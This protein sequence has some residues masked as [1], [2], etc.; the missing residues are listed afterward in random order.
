MEG[1]ILDVLVEDMQQ[2]IH[3]NFER[4]REKFLKTLDLEQYF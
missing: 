3:T 1:E 4:V 2:L